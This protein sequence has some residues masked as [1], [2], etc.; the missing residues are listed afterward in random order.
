MIDG[1]P[2]VAGTRRRYRF[3]WVGLRFM[4]LLVAVPL[5]TDF[6]EIGR[7]PGSPREWVTEVVAGS[8]IAM[9]VRKIH[10]EQMTLLALARHDALTGLWNRRSFEETVED[11]CVR[12]EEH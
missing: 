3:E 9:L 1:K 11:D 4:Y 5:L 6:V 8:V 2:S 7:L 12:S 10:Q